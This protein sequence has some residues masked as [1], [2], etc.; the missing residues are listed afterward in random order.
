M[1]LSTGEKIGYGA[2]D[3]AVA[4]VMVSLSMIITYFYTDVYKLDP[5]DLGI[6]LFSVRVLD[7]IIDPFVGSLTDKTMTRWGRYRPFLLFLA[8]PFGISIW[9]M[10]T[11]PNMDYSIKLIWAY[12][13][14]IL[15]TLTYTF[16][17]IP[18]VS[19][20]GVITDDPQ[21]RLSANGYRFVMTK[22]ALFFVTI[23]VP[24]S[25]LYLGKNDLQKGYQLAMGLMGVLASLLFLYCFFSVRERITH[26]KPTLSFVQ[27]AKLLCQNDQWIVLGV[28][29]ALIM[30]GGIIRG[31]IAAYYAKYYLAGGDALIS[32][33]LT[34][35][36]FASILAMVACSWI[37]R[38]YDKIKMFRYSQL[39]SFV[40]GVLMYF[41]VKPEN[42]YLAFIFYFVVIFLTEMQLPVYWASIAEA[43]DYGEVKT[44]QRVSGLSFGGILFFQKFGMGLAGGF[45][46]F[47]LGYFNYQPDVKQTAQS[48]WGI[49]LMMTIIPS[50]LNLLVGLLMKKYIIN[51]SYYYELK[52]KLS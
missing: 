13:T 9:L 25:A 21:E 37:V 3:M 38:F 6:L 15:L 11:T 10:F 4:I 31:S 7:A 40:V 43:V 28:A 2:G 41:V 49:S 52:Q 33:F 18:Y 42:L 47:G 46:G 1:K 16:I 14:Y 35:G 48:L 44:G 36:V 27:Q 29:I 39:L 32:P 51:D 20:I 8:I 34:T 24:V 23:I 12:G 17:T 22:I 19:L 50:V 45:I 26:P 30:F 5:V